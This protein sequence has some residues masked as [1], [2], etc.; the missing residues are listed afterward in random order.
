[1]LKKCTVFTAATLAATLLGCGE[2]GPSLVTVTGTISL[3]GKPL[4]GAAIAFHPARDN[5]EGK[6]ADDVTG[7]EGNYKVMTDGRSG[8]APGKYNVV[9]TKM[10]A[11]NTK[12]SAEHPDDPFMAQLSSQPPEGGARGKKPTGVT[13]EEQFDREV[14]AEGGVFDFDVKAKAATAGKLIDP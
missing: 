12:A 10:P 13:I 11:A 6:S 14:P 4:E 1:M 9:I 2:S 5:T 7:P 3:N 8:V